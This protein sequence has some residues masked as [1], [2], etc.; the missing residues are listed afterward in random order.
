MLGADKEL[1]PDAEPALREALAHD[2]IGTEQFLLA[3]LRHR[4]GVAARAL[5]RLGV[6][7]EGPR[8]HELNRALARAKAQSREGHR[9]PSVAT[10]LR[11]VVRLYRATRR[12][13]SGRGI[14]VECALFTIIPLSRW[15]IGKRA[16][17]WLRTPG[18]YR[19]LR[20]A[21]PPYSRR[22]AWAISVH[23]AGMSYEI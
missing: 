7:H 12:S 14:A 1:A 20:K 3:L 19:Q 9:A 4:E 11:D 23:A 10:F 5:E 15:P 17:D 13:P 6:T 8:A 18:L 22:E 2:Y 16:R 21:R